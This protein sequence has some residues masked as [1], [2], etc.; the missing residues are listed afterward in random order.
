MAARDDTTE[1]A[2]EAFF[3]NIAANGRQPL[4]K[5]GAGSIQFEITDG[6]HAERWHVAID[7]GDVRV[8]R[9]VAH[10]D[11]VARVR[12]PVFDGMVRGTVNAMAATLR[13]DITVEG[14]LGLVLLFQRAFPSPPAGSP[15]S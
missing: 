2:T 12:R 10:A 3:R 4:L 13:G 15:N 8:T 1:S 14:D 6:D 9:G 7:H 11:A 5:S